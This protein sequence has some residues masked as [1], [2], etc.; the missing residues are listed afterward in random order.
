MSTA[1]SSVLVLGASGGFGTL[2][3]QVL[4]KD[5]IAVRG[6][7]RKGNPR[8]DATFTDYLS[9][10]PTNPNEEVSSVG[11]NYVRLEHRLTR[12]TGSGARS[13]S[14]CDR[15]MC[16]AWTMRPSIGGLTLILYNARAS[17][18]TSFIEYKLQG[19]AACVV[20]RVIYH[21]SLVFPHP[22]ISMFPALETGQ[23]WPATSG[24]RAV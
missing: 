21:A 20:D 2:F 17:T 19:H 3:S 9:A 7:S 18:H 5:G 11:L 14:Q 22:M 23:E 16:T 24:V 10:D 1:I 12:E 4:A 13:N 15:S 8:A 6:I